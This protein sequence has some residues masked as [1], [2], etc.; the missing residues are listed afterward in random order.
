MN[1]GIP[2]GTRDFGPEELYKRRYIF[3]IIQKYFELYGYS[4]IETPSMEN[5]DT[6][7]GKYGEEG[8][9]LLFKVLNNGDFLKKVPAEIL[10]KKDSSK[11]TSHLSK[12][13]LRY[14][15]T[16]P[17]ARYAVMHRND[18]NLPFKRYQIQPVWRA[19]RP[20]KGRYQEFFQCDADV[21]GS[22][23][24]QYEAECILLF[25]QVFAALGL[26]VDIRINNRKLL[27]ALC[28]K[29]EAHDQ[30]SAITTAIDKLDKIGLDG[31]RKILEKEGLSSHQIS[32]IEEYLNSE[33]LEEITRMFDNE[34][35]GQQGIT[36]INQVYEFLNGKPLQN[37]LTFDPTLARGLSYYTGAILEVRSTE[38]NI[39]SIGGGG[40]YDNLTA[41]FG[42]E[43][44]GGMGISFGAE[45]IYDVMEELHLLD[46]AE[47]DAPV[48][49]LTLEDKYHTYGFDILQQLRANGI[50]SDLYPAG[51]KMK[52]Q[53]KYAN[54]INARYIMILGPEEWEKK[55]IAIKNMVTGKQ[56]NVD[57]KNAVEIILEKTEGGL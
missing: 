16:I 31:V 24:L 11:A 8:D 47:M 40:R 14:D 55:E 39:G 43:K 30:L 46:Q 51:A 33:S 17:F 2:K 4:P 52:K 25:D 29:V 42:G 48:L 27:S 36:E 41:L 44:L 22:E 13:G 3:N 35:E 26:A 28:R 12:R 57:I 37:K 32:I 9:Q 6:L 19:D 10:D 38:V 18:I 34:E 15:L 50:R 49:I 56:S 5:L 7:M 20:Q 1:V 53:M 45:R 21:I 54:R 23:S